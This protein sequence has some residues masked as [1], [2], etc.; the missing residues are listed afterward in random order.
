LGFGVEPA[1][2]LIRARADED[3]HVAERLRSWSRKPLIVEVVEKP[4]KR[5]RMLESLAVSGD[6]EA[7]IWRHRFHAHRS[8]RVDQLAHSQEEGRRRSD[9]DL[10]GSIQRERGEPQESPLFVAQPSLPQNESDGG[11][12]L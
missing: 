1:K 2:V 10:P 9:R 11:Y 7:G 5:A 4:E 3:R 12:T 8:S 6:S